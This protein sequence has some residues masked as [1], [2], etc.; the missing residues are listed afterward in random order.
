MQKPLQ[1]SHRDD[2]TARADA[3]LSVMGSEIRKTREGHFKWSVKDFA[4]RLSVTPSTVRRIESGDRGVSL[5]LLAEA[6]WLLDCL[7]QLKDLIPATSMFPMPRKA[8]N[9]AQRTPAL[10]AL[11]ALGERISQLRK[12]RGWSKQRFAQI[13]AVTQNALAQIESGKSVRVGILAHI[14]IAFD[15]AHEMGQICAHPRNPFVG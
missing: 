13:A 10:L 2:V 11:S 14:C 4:E 1:P 12:R 3:A 7:P 9:F 15:L 8:R 6:C 5:P